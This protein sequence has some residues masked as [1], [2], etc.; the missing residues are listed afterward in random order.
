M[1]RILSAEDDGVNKDKGYMTIEASVVIPVVLIGVF[2]TLAGL[3][4]MFE[5]SVIKAQEVETLY[6]IPL[7]Y[8]RDDIVGSYLEEKSYGDTLEYGETSSS[9]NYSHHNA[10]A[11]GE[12]EYIKRFKVDSEREI[13]L[14]VDRLRRWQFYDDI[15]EESGN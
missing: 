12:L 9:G 11:S 15:S 13:D 8:I 6:Q 3:I 10:S 7:G 1:R 14:C 2:I 4:I 5:K